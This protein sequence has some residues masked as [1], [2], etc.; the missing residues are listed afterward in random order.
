[1]PLDRP[2]ADI[3]TE[4]GREWA[5]NPPANENEI[6]EL[7][8]LVHFELPSEY[9]A[10]LRY[11]NGGFGK[12]DS[13]P[14]LFDLDSIEKSIQYNSTEFRRSVFAEFWFFLCIF[15]I[16]SAVNCNF[17]DYHFF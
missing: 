11:C 9:I 14:V 17:A 15:L 7:C 6:T 12:L 8:K 4:Q 2:I 1:M 16:I 10:L 5:A 3:L 13:P